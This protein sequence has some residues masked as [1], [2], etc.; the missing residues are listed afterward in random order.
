MLKKVFVFVIN[1]YF[2]YM[3]AFFLKQEIYF[4][5]LFTHSSPCRKDQFA[6]LYFE[7]DSC[8]CTDTLLQL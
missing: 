8:Y 6:V 2:Y 7:Q 1:S 4:V 3:D 5:L